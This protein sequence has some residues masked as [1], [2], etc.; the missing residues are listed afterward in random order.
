M[1]HAPA[2]LF[3]RLLDIMTRLRGPAGV[4]GIASRR[5]PRSSPTSSKRPTKS[6][7]PSSPV[8]PTRSREELGDLLF[9]VVFHAQI[10]A[11]RGEFAMA[12]VLARPHRQDDEPPSAR[13]RRRRGEHAG[14][15]ARAV[16]SASSSARRRRRAGGARSSTAFRARCPRWC[17]PSASQAKAA[18]VGL[19]LARRAGGVGEGAR[20]RSRGRRTPSRRAIRPGSA[21]ELGDVLFSLVNVAR[22]ASIDA[23]DALHGA[24]EKFRRRFTEHGGRSE[25]AGE[26]GGQRAAGRARA[27]VGG[28]QGAERRAMKLK[29]G[30]ATVAVET[31]RHHQTARST[32]SSTPPTPRSRWAPGSRPPSSARAGC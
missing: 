19:R 24:I 3:E 10:A 4:P 11:E 26:V 29:I 28:G 27:V 30:P 16:G 7:R 14:R 18:R 1:T 15:S 5:E 9:Q 21:E 6:S 22:L 8:S 23:E 31:R 32:P 25:R 12:D 17:A 20:R 2:A 13:L